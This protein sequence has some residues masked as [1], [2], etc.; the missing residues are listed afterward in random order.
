[1]ESANDVCSP[2]AVVSSED[3]MQLYFNLQADDDELDSR[4]ALRSPTGANLSLRYNPNPQ[5]V[6]AYLG[7]LFPFCSSFKTPSSPRPVDGRD[8]V[9]S[10]AHPPMYSEVSPENPPIGS[11]RF[12]KSLQTLTLP[13]Q[14]QN[15][16][17]PVGA[18]DVRMSADNKLH[19][20]DRI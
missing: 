13:V 14:P 1:M 20:G 6:A 10:E 9:C 18:R 19:R 4:L 11:T 3:A 8:R 5:R 2:P 17:S 7:S 16:E 12:E 15:A